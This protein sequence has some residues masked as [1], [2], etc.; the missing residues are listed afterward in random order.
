MTASLE[1]LEEQLVQLR[2]LLREARRA[3]D[4]ATVAQVRCELREV[5]TA[6]EAALDAEE[7]VEYDTRQPP[8]PGPTGRP[9]LD[10]TPSS[11]P[12]PQ[13]KR[14]SQGAVPVREQVHQALTLLGAPAA[15][16]LI[17]A[18]HE[19]FFSGS[20]V[21]AKLASLRRDEERSFNAQGYARPYYICAALTHD[22]LTPARGLLAV[23]VWPLERRVLGPLSPRVDFLTHAVGTAEQIQRLTTAGHPPSNAAWQL[24]RRFALN[25]PGAYAD[26][27]DPARVIS[28]AHTEA[29]VHQE[30]DDTQRS[31]AAERARSGLTDSQRLFGAA[32][33][34]SAR[35]DA[36]TTG[37]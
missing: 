13:A 18:A 20:L 27:L 34:H 17:S 16:K 19:A 12:T 31:V 1:D 28:A 22:H 32:R 37:R 2:A 5:E 14:S 25:I 7:A 26:D 35:R 15:P 3:R 24:L 6:W 11:R 33:P 4:S 36:D 29:A 23:S 30:S 10:P 9:P 8:S 21:A